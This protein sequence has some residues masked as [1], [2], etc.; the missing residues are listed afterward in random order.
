M[1]QCAPA[2]DGAAEGCLELGIVAVAARRQGLGLEGVG[3]AGRDVV[4]DAAY[5]L[6]AE[7]DL[8]CTLENLDA[9]IAANRRVEIGGVVAIGCK[10]ER[11]AILEKQ[12]LG[13]AGRV[14][15]ADTDVGAHA[16]AFLVARQHAGHGPQR[17]VDG[18]DARALELLALDRGARSRD[19]QQVLPTANDHDA[20]FAQ[21]LAGLIGRGGLRR[22]GRCRGR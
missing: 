20:V 11:D 2:G 9:V 12:N 19:A 15:T 14:E 5:G 3:D 22:P 21:R 10:G 17:L 7:P 4:D 18:E 6:R 13:R 16:E 8:A 1:G